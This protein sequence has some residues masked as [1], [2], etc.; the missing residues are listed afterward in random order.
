MSIFYVNSKPNCSLY[1]LG[2]NTI[3]KLIVQFHTICVTKTLN[4]EKEK[5]GLHINENSAG[6]VFFFSGDLVKAGGVC[7]Q[8]GFLVGGNPDLAL[9]TLCKLCVCTCVYTPRVG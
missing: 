4:T 9:T 1:Q 3:Q 2:T 7:C 8:G 6:L 5:N